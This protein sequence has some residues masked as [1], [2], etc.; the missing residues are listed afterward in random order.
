[1]IHYPKKEL[2]SKT[3]VAMPSGNLGLDETRDDHAQL[4]RAGTL[5]DR[6][7]T[8]QVPIHISLE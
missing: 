8:A 2:H 4:V 1:M 5:L 6:R 3:G 7:H